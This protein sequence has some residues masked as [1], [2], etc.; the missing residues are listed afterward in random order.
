VGD[1]K[2]L[3][4]T[5]CCTPNNTMVAWVYTTMGT[6]PPRKELGPYGASIRR[7]RGGTPLGALP[8]RAPREITAATSLPPWAP[9]PVPIAPLSPGRPVA[10][11]RATGTFAIVRGVTLMHAG[12]A[13]RACQRE[14]PACVQLKP[15]RMQPHSLSVQLQR[16]GLHKKM[17]AHSNKSGLSQWMRVP[18]DRERE[19]VLTCNLEAPSACRGCLGRDYIEYDSRG[20]RP[21]QLQWRRFLRLHSPRT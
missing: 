12:M 13:R 18:D 8:L 7:G 20:S 21:Q 6:T 16:R 9:I 10:R 17:L 1:T 2:L 3:E 19:E 11:R 4:H 14:T 5:G 15:Q